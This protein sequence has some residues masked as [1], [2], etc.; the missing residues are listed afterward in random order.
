MYIYTYVNIKIQQL[1]IQDSDPWLL[2]RIVGGEKEAGV[3]EGKKNSVLV[4]VL[5]NY[6]KGIYY[7]INRP[8]WSCA[9][10]WDGCVMN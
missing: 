1:H 7:I 5:C 8:I 4:F 9:N 2:W 10:Q 6:F 3:P